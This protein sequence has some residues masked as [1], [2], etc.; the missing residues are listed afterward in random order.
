MN[1][2]GIR[3]E[4]IFYF[5]KYC[6]CNIITSGRLSKSDYDIANK[7][8]KKCESILKKSM[9]IEEGCS[10]KYIISKLNKIN[11]NKVNLW[12]FGLLYTI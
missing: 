2:D 7:Y 6:C 1:T 3:A 9:K 10:N 8:F 5:I 4:S 12:L 11:D